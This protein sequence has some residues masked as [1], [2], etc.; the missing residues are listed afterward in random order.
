MENETKIKQNI[1]SHDKVSVKYDKI[2]CEIFNPKEQKRLKGRLSLALKNIDTGSVNNMALDYGCGS[3][4]L[5]SHLINMGINTYAADVS[6]KFLKLVNERHRDTGLL[7]TIKINGKDLSNINNN[8]FDIVLAYSVLH[9]IPDY[10]AAIKEMVRVL[11]QG[12]VLYL[13]HERPESFWTSDKNYMEFSN[14]I[15]PYVFVKKTWKRFFKFSEYALYFHKKLN[16]RYKVE[17]DIHVW[18][19]DHIEW[20]K[21]NEVL[22]ENSCELIF[23]EEYLHYNQGYPENIYLDYKDKCKDMALLI[24]IK[25]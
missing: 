9:H 17:G 12:G 14:S 3:G 19:D 21:I 22:K 25:R 24:A 6:L 20:T 5:T 16:P 23:F 18:P 15:S 8:F 13:D 1:K 2:H 10:I 4:N 7:K 11:K